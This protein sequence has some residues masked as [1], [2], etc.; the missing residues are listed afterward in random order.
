[1]VGLCGKRCAQ[2]C[3][4]GVWYDWDVLVFTGVGGVDTG[5][6]FDGNAPVKL[7]L[8][9][10]CGEEKKCWSQIVAILSSS[11]FLYILEALTVIRHNAMLNGRCRMTRQM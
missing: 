7:V 11:C 6:C 3:G 2:C 1:M 4:C 10:R 5:I 9:A 8:V